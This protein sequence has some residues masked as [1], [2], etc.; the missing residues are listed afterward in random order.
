MIVAGF[1]ARAGAGMDS[2]RAAFDLASRDASAVTALAG[3]R[4]KASPLMAL[5]ESLALPLHLFD[6]PE[7]T[8][9]PTL[10]RS[11]ASLDAHGTG[12]VA[13]ASALAAAGPDARLLAPRHVSPDGMAT[14]AIAQ[15]SAL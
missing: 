8:A 12:S 6:P 10:T 3:L 11:Q 7:L 14:C 4:A 15:G 2:L 9:M 5:A 13:E 1:G